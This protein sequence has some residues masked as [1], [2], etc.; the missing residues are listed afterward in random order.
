[1]VKNILI[2][3]DEEDICYLL[4][5]ILKRQTDAKIDIA[6]SCKTGEHLLSKQSYDLAFLDMQLGDGTG[7]DLIHFIKNES[8]Q[9]PFIAVISAHTTSA[10]IQKVK[11]LSVHEF[12]QKPLSREKIINCYLAAAG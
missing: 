11:D 2:V 7:A 8:N 6:N 10:D 4:K 1:M 3:D 12:I 5:S 9:N